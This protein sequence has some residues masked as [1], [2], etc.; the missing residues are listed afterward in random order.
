M[1]LSVRDEKK[2]ML[3]RTLC[4][5]FGGKTLRRHAQDS[6]SEVETGRKDKVGENRRKIAYIQIVKMF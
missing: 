2:E 3:G 5:E 1:N 4:P 6:N